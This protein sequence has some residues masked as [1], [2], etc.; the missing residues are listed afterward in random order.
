[1]FVLINTLLCLAILQLSLSKSGYGKMALMSP[2]ALVAWFGLVYLILPTV[3]LELGFQSKWHYF[4][5]EL[6]MIHRAQFPFL[7][8]AASGLIL[9]WALRKA[10]LGVHQPIRTSYPNYTIAVLCIIISSLAYL[11]IY[12]SGALTFLDSESSN[13]VNDLS[14]KFLLSFVDLAVPGIAIA[15]FGRNKISLWLVFL[16]AVICFGY[17]FLGSRYRIVLL[18][19]LALFFSLKA[20]S[21]FYSPMRII[22]L[23]LIIF[24][25]SIVSV[26]RSYRSGFDMSAISGAGSDA[27]AKGIAS[28]TNIHFTMAAVLDYVPKFHDYVYFEPLV[29]ASTIFVPRAIWPD[30]PLPD[31]LSAISS[32]L[33]RY[34]LQDTGA[35]L[36]VYGE[37]YLMGGFLGIF[38]LSILFLFVMQFL[39]LRSISKGRYALAATLSC[40]SAYA[41]TR[42]Y[43][44]QTMLSFVF[45]VLPAYLSYLKFRVSR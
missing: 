26:G 9:S 38:F 20:G 34:G 5:D 44:A 33:S 22:Y 1:M 45:M 4:V 6:A 42:G 16:M 11:L 21:R 18:I 43:L 13:S 15:I 35:A 27:L 29:I 3:S 36:P 23:A 25:L 17:V 8:F 10:S 28:D 31:Y 32:S 40:F 41:Y 30:K 24:G 7:I 12:L 19:I 37:W 2:L 39:F 14:Y